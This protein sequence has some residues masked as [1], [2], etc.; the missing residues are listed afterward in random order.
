[1]LR[2][3]ETNPTYG[4]DYELENGDILYAM[5]WNG[6]RYEISNGTYWTPVYQEVDEDEFEI[7]GFE[8]H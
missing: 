7:I 1:M 8:K 2:I 4:A 3:K 6:E 5:D